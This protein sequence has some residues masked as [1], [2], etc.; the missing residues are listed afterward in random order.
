M[1]R[2]TG[3]EPCRWHR[4]LHGGFRFEGGLLSQEEE[5]GPNGAYQKIL[6]LLPLKPG[7]EVLHFEGV[8]QRPPSVRSCAAESFSGRLSLR[9]SILACSLLS[10]LY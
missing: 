5:A 9:V 10:Q 1:R 2:C 6:P 7:H 3:G 4:S 8:L